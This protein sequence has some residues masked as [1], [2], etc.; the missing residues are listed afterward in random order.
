MSKKLYFNINQIA[1]YSQYLT[2]YVLKYL[3]YNLKNKNVIYTLGY[4]QFC[5][6]YTYPL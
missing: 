4:T 2:M 6:L 3:K 1:N 5:A